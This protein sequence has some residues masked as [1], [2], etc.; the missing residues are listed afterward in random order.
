MSPVTS[1]EVK[2][3]L[4]ATK[5]TTAPGLMDVVWRTSRPWGR[6]AFVADECRS[7]AELLPPELGLWP[8]CAASKG[9]API[10]QSDFRLLTIS[11][12]MTRIFHRVLLR[13]LATTDPLPPNQ[14]GF[15][16]EEGCAANLLL[17]GESLK[18]A[19]ARP[20][21][22]YMV[23]VD[24]CKA[25]YSVGHPAL[26]TV[27]KSWESGLRATW[28]RYMVRPLPMSRMTPSLLNGVMQAILYPLHYLTL[29]LTRHCLP[30][31]G[32][33]VWG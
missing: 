22:L 2:A 4:A 9:G 18:R 5:P 8:N 19:K 28:H 6:S 29:H 31:P 7:F 27:C 23:F 1:D 12:A 15:T 32:V 10:S 17:I 20:S 13:L 26:V 11:P 14:R 25:F 30:F 3:T 24:F 33:S 21:S 16:E